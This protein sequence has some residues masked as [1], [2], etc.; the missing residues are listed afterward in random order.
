R[1]WPGV[2]VQRLRETGVALLLVLMLRL[3]LQRL[4]LRV[5]RRWRCEYVRGRATPCLQLREARTRAGTWPGVSVLRLL[6]CRSRGGGQRLRGRRPLR[7]HHQLVHGRGG[8]NGIE[9]KSV[10]MP[11]M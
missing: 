3:R 11:Q 5:A 1:A 6:P 7:E 2:L 9:G 4:H 10:A 8:V